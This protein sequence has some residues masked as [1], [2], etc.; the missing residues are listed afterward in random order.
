MAQHVSD[1]EHAISVLKSS[2]LVVFSGDG[3][4]V[5]AYPFTMEMREYEVRVNRHRVHAMCALD[6]LAISPMFGMKTQIESRCRLS[7]G[8]VAIQ[9]AGT[10]IENPDEAGDVRFGIDWGAARAGASCANS[11]CMEMIFLQDG[12]VAREWLKG[13]A[14]TKQ[15]FTLPEAVEFARRFFVPLMA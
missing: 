2:D 4:P 7:G 11:L 6:A 12:Q 8:R 13:D 3:D 9:Q 15:A 1:P 10:A 14:G 5:G